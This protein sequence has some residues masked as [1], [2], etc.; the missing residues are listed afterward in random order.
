MLRPPPRDASGSKAT[1]ETV[2]QSLRRNPLCLVAC[3]LCLGTR[4]WAQTGKNPCDL[5]Q[6]G[7]VNQI[8][9][10]LAV[11]MVLGVAACTA[12]VQAAGICNVLLVQRVANAASGGM[13]LTDDSTGHAVSLTWVRSTSPDVSGYNVYRATVSGQYT[14]INSSL[15]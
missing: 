10:V 12:T 13:C 2:V 4:A 8:D 5:N 1:E 3:F 11:N 6:D 15:V 9:I 7:T 14:K